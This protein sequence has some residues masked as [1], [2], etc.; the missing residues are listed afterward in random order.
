MERSIAE[1]HSNYFIEPAGTHSDFESADSDSGSADS[2]SE[3]ADSDS[4]AEIAKTLHDLKRWTEEEESS[5]SGDAPPS[6][7]EPSVSVTDKVR[8]NHGEASG[9]ACQGDVVVGAVGATSPDEPRLRVL[10]GLGGPTGCALLDTGATFSMIT[11]EWVNANNLHYYPQPESSF[12]R[13]G[14]DNRVRILG[15]IELSPS[16]SHLQLKPQVYKVIDTK[17]SGDLPIILGTD[18]IRANK[19]ILDTARA[20]RKQVSANSKEVEGY[21]PEK[22]GSTL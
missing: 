16:V 4:E 18:F 19:L 11:H 13:F 3:S 8:G 7:S 9:P 10:L 15:T 21:C 14:G 22:S 12:S 20:M 1:P 6:A 5:Q 2:D 17:L